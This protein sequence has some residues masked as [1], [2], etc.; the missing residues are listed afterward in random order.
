MDELVGFLAMYVIAFLLGVVF[1]K[2]W[3]EL[4]E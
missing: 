2:I 1:T 4:F 3:I